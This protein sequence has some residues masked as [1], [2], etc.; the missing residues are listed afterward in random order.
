MPDLKPMEVGVMFWAGPDPIETLRDVKALGVRCGQ[1]GIPGEM[2]LDGAASAWKAALAAEEFTLVTIFAAY[3][4]ESYA[5]APT[6]QRTVGFIPP[7]TRAERERRTYEISDFAAALGVPS[8]A[9]HIGFVPE[10]KSH[11]DYVAVRDLVRRICD[12]A[13]K[14]N[15]TFA[16]ETGQEPARVL[17]EFLRDVDRPNLGINFD[18]ANMILYGTGDP[19]EALDL[20]APHVISVHC[21]DGDWPPKDK[22]GALGTEQPLGKGSVGIERFIAKLKQIGFQGPLNIEREVEDHEQRRRDIR[23]AVEL[24]RRLTA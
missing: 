10:D 13:A 19:I 3:S 7:A 18:P 9:C 6:V 2:K 14:H 4:G 5:D 17:L 23:E 20:L 21:K 8:I 15:Q 11:P 1:M 12:H 22:P 24:L 16:L